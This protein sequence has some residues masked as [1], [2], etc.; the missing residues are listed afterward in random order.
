MTARQMPGLRIG[1]LVHE[2]QVPILGANC[3]ELLIGAPRTASNALFQLANLHAYLTVLNECCNAGVRLQY[4]QREV[5]LPLEPPERS[6]PVA[7]RRMSQQCREL[8]TQARKQ[9]L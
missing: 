8:P 9:C 3:K 1:Y 4:Q 6:E 2:D 5:A 7:A